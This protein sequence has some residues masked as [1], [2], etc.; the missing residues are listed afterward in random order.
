MFLL[1]IFEAE[2][3]FFYFLTKSATL[4]NGLTDVPNNQNHCS[5]RFKATL[6][7]CCAHV[8][9][10]R[11]H[12]MVQSNRKKVRMRAKEC[13]RTRVPMRNVLR[14]AQAH[15]MLCDFGISSTLNLFQCYG[16]VQHLHYVSIYL[17][18]L[19][20]KT[21]RTVVCTRFFFLFVKQIQGE[22][23][24]FEPSSTLHLK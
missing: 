9:V 10:C 2:H 16:I 15:V 20:I 17:Y 8:Y 14:C 19:W 23:R 24:A 5:M 22:K 12:T 3:F 13:E 1:W 7:L 6:F 21:K 18:I 4:P 11:K